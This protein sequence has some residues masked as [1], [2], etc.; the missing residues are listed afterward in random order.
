MISLWDLGEVL[1]DYT[2]IGNLNRPVE[3][4]GSLAT[5]NFRRCALTFD[6]FSAPQVTV[7]YEQR[8]GAVIPKRVHTIVISVQHDD[9][10]SLEDQKRVLKEKVEPRK[11]TS[12]GSR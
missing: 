1:R 4:S 6:F 10:I 3:K 2:I 12:Q 8:D 9:C 11:H 7:H 5:G